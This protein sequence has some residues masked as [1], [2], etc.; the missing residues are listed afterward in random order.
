MGIFNKTRKVSPNGI[1]SSSPVG[2]PAD[3]GSFQEETSFVPSRTSLAILTE[4]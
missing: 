4:P 3:A 1:A 2:P